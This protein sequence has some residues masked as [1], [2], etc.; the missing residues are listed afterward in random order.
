M[1]RRVFRGVLAALLLSAAFGAP[2]PAAS[3]DMTE[4]QGAA[5]LK[6]LKEIRKTLQRMEK[7][8]VAAPA[9][10]RAQPSR[11]P[12]GPA[13]VSTVG[14][15]TI[16]DPKAPVT[17]VEFTDYQCPY[18]SRFFRNTLPSIKRDFIDTGKV[19]L[20]VKD[21][22]LSFHAN[23][24]KAAQAAHCAGEQ[25]AFWPMHDKLFENNRR[26]EAQQLPGYAAALK[27]DV[28]AFTGCLASKRHLA[29]ISSDSA[30]ARTAGITG[31]PSFIVGAS[32]KDVIDGVGIRGAQPYTVFKAQIEKLLAKPKLIDKTR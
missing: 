7:Q 20:V 14:R 18:C 13:K 4:A 12:L 15:P 19:R 16:G 1:R 31:T 5:I 3:D 10:Q 17:L 25:D 21:L 24:R 23:A 32:T 30:H 27:L 2:Q 29:A 26:L 9:A 8:R 28:D 11:R 22:P 6:E